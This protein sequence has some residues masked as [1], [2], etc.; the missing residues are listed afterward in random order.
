MHSAPTTVDA[1]NAAKKPEVI[2][3]YNGTKGGVDTIDQMVRTYTVKRMTRRWPLVIFY[4]M[5]DVSAL[6][7]FIIWMSLHPTDF[8]HKAT[9][10]RQFIMALGKELCAMQSPL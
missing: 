1:T 4:N 9:R 5:V 8:V 3:Y 2:L 6:N 10:R 7:A